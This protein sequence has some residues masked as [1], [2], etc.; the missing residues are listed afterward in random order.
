M[1]MT[2]S[3]DTPEL[4]KKW[5]AISLIAGAVE[6]RVWTETGYLGGE[7]RLMYP[8]LYTLFL[9]APGVGKAIIEKV[10][11]IWR[12][13]QLPGTS[14]QAFHVGPDNMTHAAMVDVLAESLHSFLPPQGGPYEYC[15][16]LVAAEE[17][18]VFMHE[19][20][21]DFVSALNTLYNVPDLYQE[22]RRHGPAKNVEVRNPI[23][24]LLAGVQP[25]WVHDHFPDS[26]WATG[27]PSRMIMIYVGERA[28]RG[29]FSRGQSNS[30][31]RPMFM[32]QL[33]NLA[34]LYGRIEWDLDAYRLIDDWTFNNGPPTPTHSKLE[35][36]CNRRGL[37]V[38]KLAMI[39]SISR[40]RSVKLIE[41]FDVERAI[42]WLLE[43]EQ[44]MPDAFRAMIGRSDHDVIEELYEHLWRLYGISGQKGV[45]EAKLQLFLQQRVPADKARW[46]LDALVRS[47]MAELRGSTN[48]FFPSPRKDFVE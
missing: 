39:S 15:S 42:Q 25:A 29:F 37:H 8:N 26:A 17:L 33:S 27:L 47:G 32:Q 7:V 40:Y 12:T 31:D 4:F 22:R 30:P 23:L 5:A 14:Q 46:I 41:K 3:E 6:R 18:S 21:N 34:Q 45:H 35:H 13:V 19:Y 48:I 43:A 9:A 16:L 44:F 36:Y 11:G 10:K 24:N 38:G 1:K 28:N 20:S 2:E